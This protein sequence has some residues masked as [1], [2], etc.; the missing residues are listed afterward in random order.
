MLCIYAVSTIFV[1][2][3]EAKK[4]RENEAIKKRAYESH[5]REVENSTVTPLAFS[6]TRGMGREAMIFYKR[7]AS[8]LSK[9]WK[10]P[11]ASVLG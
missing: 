6:A 4:S 2:V 11:Y 10:E 9:K 1:Y 3:F 5:I 8:L 7:L